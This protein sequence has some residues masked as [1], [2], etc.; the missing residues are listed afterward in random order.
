MD[1]NYTG[2]DSCRIYHFPAEGLILT[3]ITEDEKLLMVM[4]DIMSR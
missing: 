2:I 4:N 3:K 1:F